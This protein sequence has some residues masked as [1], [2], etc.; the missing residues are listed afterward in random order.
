[1]NQQGPQISRRAEDVWFG[2]T[3]SSEEIALLYLAMLRAA[4]LTAYDMK[5]VDRD[6]G[7]FSSAYLSF[8]QFDGDLVILNLKGKEVFLDPGQKMC[9]F[10][11]VHWKHSGASGIRQSANGPAVATSPFQ[12]YTANTLVRTGDVTLDDRGAITGNFRFVM[13]G[14]EALLWRQTAIEYDKEEVRNRFDNWLRSMAPE[15][16]EAHLDHFLSLDD[17]DANLIAV[18]NVQGAPGSS[19]AKHL[20][21]PGSFFEARAHHPFV[22]QEKR[23]EPVDMHFGELITDQVVYHLPAGLAVEGAPQDAK[24]P[25]EGHASFVVRARTDPGQVIIARQLSRAFTILKPEE[26]QDLRAFYQKVAAADRQQLV[27]VA[28]PPAKGN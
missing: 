6:K 1:M 19:P 16:V 23:L 8:D 14:Q 11:T 9:P 20:M 7:A 10:Q 28:S 15:G 22:D 3:G 18:V 2:K 26:Y 17:P 25:W 4:G 27:L 12:P 5:V 24:I 21:L 13:I